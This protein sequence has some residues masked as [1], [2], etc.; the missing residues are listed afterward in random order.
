V[1]GVGVIPDVEVTLTR[2]ALLSGA[3][4]ALEAAV[5]WITANP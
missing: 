5:A 4:P 3:D 1:E 2:E